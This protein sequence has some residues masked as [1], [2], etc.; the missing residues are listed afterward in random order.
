MKSEIFDSTKMKQLREGKG[1]S[2]SEFAKRI[3]CTRQQVITWESGDSEPRISTLLKICTIF[4][5][6]TSFFIRKKK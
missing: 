1:L 6:P 4:Q 3:N 2:K 5:V